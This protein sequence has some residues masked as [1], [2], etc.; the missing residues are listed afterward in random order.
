M[1]NNFPFPIVFDME[2]YLNNPSLIHDVE[3]I[4]VKT[5]VMPT[6]L[7]YIETSE[8]EADVEK[9]I[10]KWSVVIKAINKSMYTNELTE[11]TLILLSLF[12]KYATIF[13]EEY[14]VEKY[15]KLSITRK[16]DMCVFDI[17]YENSFDGWNWLPIL[18]KILI[19]QLNECKNSDDVKKIVTNRLY[20]L[21]KN[22]E[23]TKLYI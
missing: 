9:T 15:G 10:E 12:A 5:H 2:Q 17:S 3:N 21:Y 6:V 14:T 19:N 8:Y 20:E 4:Y 22:N 16:D 7:K 23:E 11:E 1:K 18:I 13:D